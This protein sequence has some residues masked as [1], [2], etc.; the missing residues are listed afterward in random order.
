MSKPNPKM[1]S[2]CDNLFRQT[3]AV[4]SYE[5][6]SA[7]VTRHVSKHLLSLL[8]PFTSDSV[9]HDNA[10]GPGICTMDILE[11]TAKSSS[12]PPRIYAT[13]YSEAMIKGA[14]DYIDKNKLSNVTAQVMDGSELTFEDDMFTHSITNLGIFAFPDAEAGAG[15]IYRTL[16]PGGAAAVTV[17]KHSGNIEFVNKVIKRINP[18]AK[19]FYPLKEDWSP[20]EKIRGV[21][22]VGGFSDENVKMVEHEVRWRFKDRADAVELMNSPFWAAAKEPLDEEQLKKYDDT[23]WE[24]LV[25]SGEAE[26]GISM[27]AWIALATK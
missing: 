3:S 4:A 20:E 21:M 12:P 1:L 13:D 11:A 22:V 27:T 6:A 23:V 18:D 8:P 15:H 10:C 24:L 19:P 17:W 7:G 5:K 26:T 14:Q 9:V 16:K 2:F 25:S